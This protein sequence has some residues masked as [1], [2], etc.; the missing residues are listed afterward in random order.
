MRLVLQIL[1][2]VLGVLFGI[3]I[4]LPMAY[5][6]L[7]AWRAAR[8]FWLTLFT[9]W[10]GIFALVYAAVAPDRED[11]SPQRARAARA[12]HV[13][14]DNA[15]ALQRTLVDLS[16]ALLLVP[17]ATLLIAMWIAEAAIAAISISPQWLIES[18]RKLVN[19]LTQ[20][21]GDAWAYLR[22][23]W[24][25]GQIRVRFE[26]RV[27]EVI[28]TLNQPSRRR[29]VISMFVIAH[30]LGSVVAH[31]ALSGER[32]SSE[33]AKLFGKKDQPTFHFITVGSALDLVW[34]LRREEDKFRFERALPHAIRWLD[35]R[36][37]EDPV[38]NKRGLRL[39]YARQAGHTV[40]R[41]LV[42]HNQ[43]DLFSNHATY[44]NNSEEVVAE[45]L[46]SITNQHLA[47]DLFM[48]VEAR[49]GRVGV[50]ACLKILAWGT[51]YAFGVLALLLG[52]DAAVSFLGVTQLV[53]LLPNAIGTRLVA[54][55]KPFE[56]YFVTPV[57]WGIA[58]AGVTAVL[59]VTV[60]GWAWDLW[61][62]AVKYSPGKRYSEARHRA[63]HQVHSRR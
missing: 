50:L 46:N 63:R 7:L 3:V 10:W 47:P 17:F 15:L 60:V 40:D 39:P 11:E 28:S 12:F 23:P 49:L 19:I 5:L 20:H 45:V 58:T 25:S 42:V 1:V 14:A 57:I 22:R 13:F 32:L 33:I 35:V 29:R 41:E 55:E 52:G 31:E 21:L 43:V 53:D 30:S 37:L 51:P 36:A 26:E 27:Y 2:V 8:V 59:Y 54:H 48:D 9:I 24:E 18:H 56:R 44:W 6:G 62:R 4:L 16:V 34:T 38:V 61:D